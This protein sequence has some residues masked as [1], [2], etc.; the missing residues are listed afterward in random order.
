MTNLGVSEAAEISGGDQSESNGLSLLDIVK[1]AVRTVNT[2]ACELFCLQGPPT[3]HVSRNESWVYP[4]LFMTSDSALR[5]HA[6]RALDRAV[7]I[8]VR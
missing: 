8:R 1:H 6:R 5:G 3:L 7:Q 4:Y 2:C